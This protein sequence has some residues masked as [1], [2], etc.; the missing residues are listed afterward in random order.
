MVLIPQWKSVPELVAKRMW[1]CKGVINALMKMISVD[2][3]N[4]DVRH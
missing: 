4:K 3:M 2:K 1:A